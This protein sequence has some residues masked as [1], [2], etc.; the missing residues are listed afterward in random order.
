MPIVLSAKR[1]F[2]FDGQE[3]L[4]VLPH[5]GQVIIGKGCD[6]GASVTIDIEA[7]WTIPS[8]VIMS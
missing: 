1:G 6:I 2:G 7:R 3:D 4:Q 8:L 5:L